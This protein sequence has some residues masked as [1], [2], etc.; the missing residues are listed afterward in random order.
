MHN[1]IKT[2]AKIKSFVSSGNDLKKVSSTISI[3]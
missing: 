3:D 2:I 1:T